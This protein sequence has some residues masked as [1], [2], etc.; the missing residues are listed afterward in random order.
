[1]RKLDVL[2]SDELRRRLRAEIARSSQARLLHRLHCVLL[3]AEGFS[4]YRVA[5]WFGEDPKTLERWVHL[6][7]EFGAQRLHDRPHVGRRARLTAKQAD[8]LRLYLAAEPP[9]EG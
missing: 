7:N 3:I 5:A 8:L 9:G 4:C 6:W 1:M 2:K